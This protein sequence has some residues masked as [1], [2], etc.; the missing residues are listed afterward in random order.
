MIAGNSII[1]PYRAPGFN[2]LLFNSI[3]VSL[4]IIGVSVTFR[5]ILIWGKPYSYPYPFSTPLPP[6]SF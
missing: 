4:K 2:L 1:Y 3:F 6:I 5:K